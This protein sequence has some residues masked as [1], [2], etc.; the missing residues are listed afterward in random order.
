MK[1][2]SLLLFTFALLQ[3]CA[4]SYH[5]SSF[6]GGY[7][8]TQLGENIFR[9]S[10]SG[11]GYTGGE[12]VADFVLLRSAELALENGYAFFVVIDEKDVSSSYTYT[13]PTTSNTSA[14]VY[15]YGNYTNGNATTTTY[16][17]QTYN[18]RSP[19]VVSTILCFKE[20][21]NNAFTFDAKF[22]LKS[23]SAKYRIKKKDQKL[24]YYGG[25]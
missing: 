13:T 9:V 4:T 1:K 17:G 3:G 21:P 12:R 10:F 5:K 22:I 16:G 23:I 2:L 19:G 7:S 14:S 18:I 15:R 11:N 25:L 24:K 6:N 20:K 8:E